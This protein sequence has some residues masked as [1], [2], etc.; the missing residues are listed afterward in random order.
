M[1]ISKSSLLGSLYAVSISSL[2]SGSSRAPRDFSR[3][4]PMP[5]APWHH[6]I[7]KFS[8][9]SE[10]GK[11]NSLRSL[12]SGQSTPPIEPAE[13]GSPWDQT[14]VLLYARVQMLSGCLPFCQAFDEL[15]NYLRPHQR[16]KQ[17]I[18][19]S[20]QRRVHL[21][22]MGDLKRMLQAA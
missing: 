18:S 7:M 2:I 3:E 1:V 11:P 22:R 4:N 10:T 5:D 13:T 8:F 12:K 21:E 15:R 9:L 6:A 16:M 19:L 20:A 17:A 14:A